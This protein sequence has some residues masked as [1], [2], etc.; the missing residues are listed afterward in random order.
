VSKTI[1]EI[2]NGQFGLAVVDTAAVGYNEGWQSPGGKSV[3]TVVLSDY[4]AASSQF[5]CQITSGALE[6][7]PD[8]TTKDIPATW[9]EAGETIPTPAKTSFEW[10]MTF[11]QDPTV[12]NGLNRFL[13]E[14]DTNE[15]YLYAGFDSTNPPK[16]IGRV[17]LAAGTI[18]GEAR[19]TLTAD[20][21]L[22]FSTKPDID[23][24]TTGDH[25]VVVGSG[26]SR[27]A[28][29]P[30]NAFPADVDITASDQTNAAK[31]TAEG[32]TASPTSAW[33][34]TQKIS[35]GNYDFF[36]NGTAWAPG[37]AA[38]NSAAPGTTF[39][40]DS[41]ITASDSTNAA[42]LAGEGFKA[43]PTSNWTTGQKITIGTF[44]FNWTG[45][46]WAAGSHA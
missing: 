17:R 15:A 45:S 10:V 20:L 24:G 31:L 7:T 11:L 21:T 14:N 2:E 8:T 22:P 12:K 32:F 18:G 37:N 26:L 40:A 25:E 46:A 16:L 36:W 41:H 43:N 28:A 23:F 44:D 38:R 34:G 29:K 39:P 6:A 3:D 1:F 13:F 9:C 4:A 33:T 42:K 19:S 30:G 35:V 5:T 27:S